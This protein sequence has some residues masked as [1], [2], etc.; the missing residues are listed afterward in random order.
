MSRIFNQIDDNLKLITSLLNKLFFL[1]GSPGRI[2]L[3]W[4]DIVKIWK[5]FGPHVDEYDFRSSRHSF[6]MNNNSFWGLMQPSLLE[7]ANSYAGTKTK[8]TIHPF[9]TS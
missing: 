8:L 1:E 4:N 7:L 3:F 5:C 6:C 2:Y 9:S